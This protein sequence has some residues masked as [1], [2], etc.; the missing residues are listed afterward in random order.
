MYSPAGSSLALSVTKER[1]L[2][3]HAW[4]PKTVINHNNNKRLQLTLICSILLLNTLAHCHPDGYR[5]QD[6]H[7][8][9]QNGGSGS[10]KEEKRLTRQSRSVS[11]EQAS[12]DFE[13]PIGNQTIPVGRDAQ[14]TC[15][16][17]NLGSFRTAWLRVE[18]KG[19]LTIHNNIITRNYRVGL[20][21]KD[22]GNTFVL[23]IKNV[24]PSDKGGYMCQINSVPM[25]YSVGYLD[26]LTPPNFLDENSNEPDPNWASSLTAGE[27]TQQRPT[28]DTTS[29]MPL[30]LQQQQDAPVVSPAG[31]AASQVVVA[32]GSNATLSCRARGHPEPVISWRR[33]DGQPI[34]LEAL[35][36]SPETVSGSS[37]QQ[38]QQKPIE[39]NQLVFS[40]INRYHS[41]AYLC[42]ASNG[43]QPSASKRQVLDVQFRPIVYL[44]QTEFSASLQQAEVQL[45]CFI[46]LNPVGSYHWVR[47]APSTAGNKQPVATSANQQEADDLWLIEHDELTASDKYDIVIKQVNSEKI[48]MVLNIRRL[49]RQDFGWYKCV[50]RNKMG[51]QSSA[52]RLSESA[53]LST[54]SGG[55][56]LPS[57]NSFRGSGSSLSSGTSNQNRQQTAGHQ[58]ES[59]TSEQQASLARQRAH[60]RS[61]WMQRSTANG[62][63]SQYSSVGSSATG[64][65]LVPANLLLALLIVSIVVTNFARQDS[66]PQC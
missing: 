17:N 8:E 32:E 31:K 66:L 6:T 5:H 36:S 27:L 3:P 57:S 38:L 4:A 14:L 15:K 30:D 12:P 45:E 11:V 58:Q 40:A 22:E 24:Q 16:I 52:I 44:P 64:A 25:K 41:G 42:I 2:G 1:A 23:T 61:S 60:A 21:N 10:G 56:S 51:L 43:V 28:L 49:D 63:R 20:V 34:Q 26:V 9:A 48:H 50:A 62:A 65:P 13:Q 18:D 7:N 35:D 46:E 39:G 37:N 33:E 59:T 53:D 47:L 55:L 19:I 29:A 54:P